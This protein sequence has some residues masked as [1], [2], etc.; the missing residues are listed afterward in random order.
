MKAEYMAAYGTIQKIVWI[1]GV[2]TELGLTY[3]KLSK[4]ACPTSLNM[5]STSALT[6][7]PVNHKRS[8]HVESNIIGFVSNWE[9]V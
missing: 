6:Q 5:Y 9:V 1:R 4:C 3:F 2:M 7:N 8:K